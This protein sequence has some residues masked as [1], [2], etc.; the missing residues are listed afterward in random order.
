MPTINGTAPC[1]ECGSK[2]DVK[3]DGRKYY[4]NCIDCRTF[5]NYQS[6]EA[7][8]RILQRL[9]PIDSVP[10]AQEILDEENPQPAQEAPQ[11]TTETQPKPPPR[12]ARVF[13]SLFDDFDELF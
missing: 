7:K 1:P 5:T 4:I 11:E 9:Q 12:K 10:E 6:K 3:H 2:Q 13:G 8:A